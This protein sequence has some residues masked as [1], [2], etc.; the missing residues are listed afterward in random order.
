[1]AWDSLQPLWRYKVGNR[2]KRFRI[3]TMVTVVNKL[4]AH[5]E[6]LDTQSRGQ[7]T[8]PIFCTYLP[9]M[10]EQYKR[11]GF[12][13]NE[14][15][16]LPSPILS[17]EENRAE[18]RRFNG[19]LQYKGERARVSKQPVQ[20]RA[21]VMLDRDGRPIDPTLVEAYDEAIRLREMRRKKKP[22]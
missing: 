12:A 8:P 15:V 9:G 19:R 2:S 5:R 14:H 17:E 16:Y 10:E 18:A 21:R 13:P 11:Y 20:T 7:K 6:W 4:Q 3:T 1:M 22:H